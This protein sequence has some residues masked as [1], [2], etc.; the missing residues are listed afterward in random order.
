MVRSSGQLTQDRAL[1]REEF[2]LGVAMF[3]W[4]QVFFRKR[5]EYLQKRPK[6]G[7]TYK[8]SKLPSSGY[9]PQTP[10]LGKSTNGHSEVLA[11]PRMHL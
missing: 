2:A 9:T 7:P 4:F 8:N 6:L 1:S 3:R 11:Q 5:L 10:A